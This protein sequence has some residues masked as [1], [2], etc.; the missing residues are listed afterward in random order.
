MIKHT[1]VLKAK[2]NYKK[3]MG[4]KEPLTKSSEQIKPLYKD[5]LLDS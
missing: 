4:I 2:S 3:L 1:Y 5:D